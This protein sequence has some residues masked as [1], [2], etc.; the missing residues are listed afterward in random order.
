MGVVDSSGGVILNFEVGQR[1]KRASG[2]FHA[3]NGSRDQSD[4]GHWRLSSMSLMRKGIAL[5]LCILN[6]VD[7]FGSAALS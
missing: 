6:P 2:G 3:R 1:L 4:V 5:V 7:P